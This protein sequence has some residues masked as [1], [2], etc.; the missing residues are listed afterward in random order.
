MTCLLGIDALNNI[1]PPFIVLKGK[2]VPQDVQDME[3]ANLVLSAQGNAWMNEDLFLK[4]ISRVWKPHINGFKRTLLIM[5]QFRVHKMANV[6]KELDACGT[7]V[8]FI[9]TGMTFYL[10]PC[11]VYLNKP[12][13]NRIKGSWQAFMTSQKEKAEGISFLDTFSF[14]REI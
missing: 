11:D 4:W 10:Q 6:L 8:L 5:D 9:P 1:L 3:G 2:S 7:D 14:Y 12:L 13:K